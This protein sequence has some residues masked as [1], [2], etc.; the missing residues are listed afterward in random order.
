MYGKVICLVV[1]FAAV[2]SA[3]PQPQPQPQPQPNPEPNADPNYYHYAASTYGLGS[4][5]T[6]AIDT[7]SGAAYN[8]YYSGSAAYPYGSYSSIYGTGYPYS[9]YTRSA[10]YGSLYWTR[11]A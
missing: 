4:P 3:F 7:R 9:S 10:V 6:A 5:Y 8:Y 1:I 2:A 11:P